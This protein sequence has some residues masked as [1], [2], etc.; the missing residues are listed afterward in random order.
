MSTPRHTRRG[1]IVR[2]GVAVVLSLFAIG[3]VAASSGGRA[4]AAA[5]LGG[6]S[7]H[8]PGISE[9]VGG[10]AALVQDTSGSARAGA[11]LAQGITGRTGPG[12]RAPQMPI[13]TRRGSRTAGAKGPVQ[14][15][16]CHADRTFL[17][18]KARND[19]G[20]SVLFVPDTSL[21]DS[22]HESLVCADCHAGYNDG[23]PHATVASVAVSC[24]RCHENQ[25]VAYHSSI[26]SAN[27][28]KKGDA[29]TCVSCHSA[30]RVLGIDDPR[31]PTYPL[32][33]AQ[34]CGSCHDKP[35]IVDAYFDAPADSA[36]RTAVGDYRHSVHGLAMSRAGLTVSATC[37]DCHGAH[38]VLPVDST[39]STLSRANVKAT[40]GACHA[41]VLTTYDSSSHGVALVTG[42]TTD[43]GQQAPVCIECHGGHKIVSASDPDWFA[44]VVTECGSCHERLLETY[45]ETYHGKATTLGSG[46]AAKCSDCHTP[47]AMRPAKDTLSSVHPANLVETCGACHTGASANFVMYKPHADPRDAE[48]NPELHIVWLAMTTLL[49]GVFGFFGLHSVLWFFR[50]LAARGEGHAG[51][52]PHAAG[53]GVATA[54][55]AEPAPGVPPA[56]SPAPPV[57]GTVGT[58]SGGAPPS[59]TASAPGA[60]IPDAPAEDSSSLA[61]T[62]PEQHTSDGGTGGDRTSAGATSPTDGPTPGT[63]ATTPT[64]PGDSSNAPNDEGTNDAPPEERA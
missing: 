42:D 39:A 18:G 48:R 6:A 35:E 29:P 20:D 43:T 11:V 27:F 50:L 2:A 62:T 8:A 37:S 54:V 63:S 38:G 44:G 3:A 56:V 24:D 28:E 57:T 40:C 55:P 60:S 47:H 16:K 53:A 33:V 58:P 10:A 25:G 4:A 45:F 21:R 49:I 31:S 1:R 64:A 30:H 46:I 9:G 51:G 17:A 41:G 22:R 19:K 5:P 12:R 14:C 34:L 36:A 13:A 32:N 23:Y 59:P 15:E 52:G 61:A 7:P 26:H